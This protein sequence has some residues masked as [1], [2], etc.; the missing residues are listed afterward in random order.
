VTATASLDLAPTLSLIIQLL[1]SIPSHVHSLLESSAFLSAARLEGVGRVLHRVI[2]SYDSEEIA[3][4]SLKDKFPII[5]RQWEMIAALG[6][7][8]VRRA[9]AELRICDASPIVRKVQISASMWL[10]EDGLNSRQILAQT[11]AS[12]VILDN[13]TLR[14]ALTLL[15]D[16]R[17]KR[18]SAILD[19]MV[20][21]KQQIDQVIGRTE[22]AIETVLSTVHAA[23]ILFGA[24]EHAGLLLQLLEEI[25]TPSLLSNSSTQLPPILSMLPNYITLSRYLPDTILNFSPSIASSHATFSSRDASIEIQSWLTQSNHLVVEGVKASIL[26][27][28]G[29]ASTLRKLWTAICTRLLDYTWIAKDLERQL[30]SAIEDRFRSIYQQH[31][32]TLVTRVPTCLTQLVSELSSSPA[33]LDTAHFLFEMQLPFPSPT[34]TIPSAKPVNDPLTVFRERVLKRLE[35]KS[36]LLDRGLNEMETSARILKDDLQDWL[37]IT[38][39][40]NLNDTK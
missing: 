6:A 16:A 31:L 8:I 39:C 38:G 5:E 23:N 9:T 2:E 12:I 21:D 13:I 15:L 34:S 7:V 1:L 17:S 25:E 4:G 3:G 26:H 28:G 22:E 36:P 29:G 14:S 35:G 10:T 27:L 40:D 33:D 20:I 30:G 37:M 19:S 11:L 24:A 18:L 32:S